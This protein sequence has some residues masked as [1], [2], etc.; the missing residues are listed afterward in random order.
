MSRR[1]VRRHQRYRR[2]APTVNGTQLPQLWWWRC[3]IAAGGC[4][5][6]TSARRV[7]QLHDHGGAGKKDAAHG[8]RVHCRQLYRGPF[9]RAGSDTG[10]VAARDPGASTAV[11]TNSPSNLRYF[12]S[13]HRNR[14]RMGT[15]AVRVNGFVPG[16]DMLPVQ[17]KMARAALGLRRARAGGE[18]WRQ[19]GYGVP[20]REGRGAASA[21]GHRDPRSSGGCG[22]RVHA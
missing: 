16:T 14:A 5:G 11:T 18:G 4:R 13:R 17:C 3:V 15:A 9:A 10:A 21:Y 2:I 20:P 1:L 19:P 6:A 12:L 7:S 8:G 22:R